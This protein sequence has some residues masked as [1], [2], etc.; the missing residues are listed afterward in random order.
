MFPQNEITFSRAL[1]RKNRRRISLWPVL[2]GS[3]AALLS[4]ICRADE[5]WDGSVSGNW[6]AAAP[7]LDNTAPA[8]GGSPLLSVLFAGDLATDY[9][10]T[11]NLGSPFVLNRL[12]FDTYSLLGV[13]I[14][15]AAGNSIELGGAAPAILQN[16]SG[17]VT[18]S[19]PLIM[20]GATGTVT[21]GGAN[22][23]ALSVTGNLSETGGPQTLVIA[24]NPPS[25]NV[26]RISLSGTNTFTGGVRLDS[27]NLALLSNTALGTGSLV[28]NGGTLSL[29]ATTIANG[30]VLNQDL[31][32]LSPTGTTL[33][34]IVSG[35][36][37]LT[38]RTTSLATALKLSGANTY[39]GATTLD[40]Y[41]AAALATND[42]GT[43]SLTGN[44]S[45][46]NSSAFNIRSGSILQI[47]A[48]STGVT[49]RLGDAT[50]VNLRSGQLAF[51][52]STGSIAQTESVGPLRSAGYS[53]VTVTAAS[54]S[55]RLTAASLDRPERGTFLFRGT[56]LGGT[57]ANGVANI[58]FTSA[59][60]G[61]VGAGAGSILPYAIGDATATGTGATFLNYSATTGLRPL[62]TAEY[63]TSLAVAD[64]L[65][66]VRLTATES[67]GAAK[68][69]NS[70]I[71]IGNT[72]SGNTTVS[73]GGALTLASGALLAT[74]GNSTIGTALDF[75]AAEASIF[76]LGTLTINGAISGTNGLT[77]SGS[78]NLLLNTANSITG[79]LTINAGL[80]SFSSE[81]A[82]GNVDA[83]VVL[84]GTGAGLSYVGNAVA[85]YLDRKSVV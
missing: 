31:V 40:Y 10:A 49:D 75:G 83:T 1:S 19:S 70:L 18:I 11:N 80:I 76:S 66:N 54:A 25:S 4:G 60:A 85:P 74:A 68:T 41:Q 9:T 17:A 8:A 52:G 57:F 42:G 23:G 55:T 56:A 37:G 3:V 82:L 6:S 16:G 13:T 58:L 21:I 62:A 35:S 29:G 5:V 53:T 84:N 71:V 59:P 48:A 61:L 12:L 65:T 67:L 26:Q 36:A 20:H 73:G 38:L 44:G 32:I 2:A 28:V 45:A 47:V 79:P 30:I 14:A 64:S 39:G 34:G 78:G 77:K 27:G 51:A 50:P 69:I 22:V 43:I 63:G 72:A 33:S 24:A 46:L 81:S 15:S 7:W